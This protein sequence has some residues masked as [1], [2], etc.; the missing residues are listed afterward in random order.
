MANIRKLKTRSLS[1]LSLS[2]TFLYL[3][4]TA[5]NVESRLA[6]STLVGNAV[7]TGSG[8]SIYSGLVSNT[9]NF[10][11]ILSSSSV[12]TLT[13]TADDLT[14]GLTPS[15]LDLSVCDNTTSLFL[16]TVDLTADVSTTILPVANGGTGVATL[17][18]GGILL[19]SG[20][21]AV[22]STGVLGDGEILI[23]DGSGA[24]AILDVGSSTAITKLG[25]VDTGTWA[26]GALTPTTVI[27]SAYL[28][29]DT[30]HLNVAQTF[31]AIKTF[32][33]STRLEFRDANCLINSPDINDL[34]IKATGD[35]D[36][37]AAIIIIDGGAVM[38]PGLP[39]S[40]PSNSGQLWNNSGVLT[41][42]A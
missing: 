28:D 14:L 37:D 35:I 3:L 8:I 25:A 34:Q 9:L 5:T 24:P 31:G 42:S 6:L 29:A 13:S 2:N 40:D 26:G 22:T 1:E 41:I 20:A 38:M 18:D 39:T 15:N 12:L 4:N 32:L 11:S 16:S 17:T 36:L 23:G 30:A 21:S 27:A 33:T 10:K 7:S 19:G